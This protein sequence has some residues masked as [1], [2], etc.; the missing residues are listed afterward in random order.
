[1]TSHEIKIQKKIV[2]EI[3]MLRY[4]RLFR[5]R[6]SREGPSGIRI[7]NHLEESPI[8]FVVIVVIKICEHTKQVS[9]LTNFDLHIISIIGDSQFL[10]L[11]GL[12]GF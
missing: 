12:P 10:P 5:H 9:L 4:V 11:M 8:N 7:D 1:M 6:N 2:Q 3:S